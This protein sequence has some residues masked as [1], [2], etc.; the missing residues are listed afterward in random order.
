VPRPPSSWGE[1]FTFCAAEAEGFFAPLLVMRLVAGFF[2]ADSAAS[3]GLAASPT[4]TVATARQR[5]NRHDRTT[6]KVVAIVI[7]AK[8]DMIITSLPAEVDSQGCRAALKLRSIAGKNHRVRLHI[9]RRKVEL[10]SLP[11]RPPGT[12]N[13]RIDLATAASGQNAT[14]HSAR[15]IAAPGRGPALNV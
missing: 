8:I 3:V 14:A 11:S 7:A 10:L 1:T 12:S 5:N 13:I 9:V 15:H 6:G 4:T 2:A